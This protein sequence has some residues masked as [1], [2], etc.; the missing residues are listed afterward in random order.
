MNKSNR[1]NI[2]LPKR[3]RRGPARTTGPGTLVGLRC[4]ADFLV[5]V[6]EWQT[7]EAPGLSRPQAI[8]ELAAIGLDCE[9]EDTAE[10]E[11]PFNLSFVKHGQKLADDMQNIH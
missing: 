9:L 2:V 3:K 7:T 11:A 10:M 1:V 8:R 6:D 5:R 4:H